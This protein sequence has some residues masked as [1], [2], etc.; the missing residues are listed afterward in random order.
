[1]SSQPPINEPVHLYAPGTPE[2]ARLRA[3]IHDM[4]AAAPHRV[5]LHIGGRSVDGHGE[6]ISVTAPHRHALTVVDAASAN[7]VEVRAAV[8]AALDA[9]HD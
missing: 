3:A 4:Q 9:H 7:A 8:D 5:P 2:R 1:M 6:R